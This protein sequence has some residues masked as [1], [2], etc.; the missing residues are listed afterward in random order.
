MNTQ[1]IFPKSLSRETFSGKQRLPFRGERAAPWPRSECRASC[2]AFSKSWWP[3]GLDG[4]SFRRSPRQEQSRHW[5]LSKLG[6]QKHLNRLEVG[7]CCQN[8][9]EDAD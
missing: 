6:L 4:R 2:P 3:L 1:I 5:H 7:S 8:V 9:V